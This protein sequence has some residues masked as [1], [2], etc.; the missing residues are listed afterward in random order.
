MKTKLITG[1]MKSGKTR[2]LVLE[3][4][5]FVIA[6]KD[7]IWFE[8]EKDTRGGSHGNFLTQRI[9]ELKNS[10]YV[11]SF[12]IKSPKDIFEK[13]TPIASRNKIQSIFIDEF[14]MLPFER[15]FFYDY[16][17]SFL[18]E[19]PIVFAGLV[20]AWSAE[21]F[22]SAINVIPFMDEILKT[23]AICMECGKPA[24]YSYFTKNW[25]SNDAVTV[26]TG[27]NYKCLCHKC[28]MQKTSHPISIDSKTN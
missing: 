15:Q 6:K 22:P 8:P 7:V 17:K 3:L 28:Y 21:L 20:S 5:Q 18:S 16:E 13:A 9:E 23:D 2:Q 14:F 10:P 1:P 27:D 4:E 11:H 25:E 19:I 24:N 26:D 12:R